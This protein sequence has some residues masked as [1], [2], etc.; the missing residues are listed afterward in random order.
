MD[1]PDFAAMCAQKQAHAT[2]ADARIE[3][4]QKQAATGRRHDTYGCPLGNH[5]HSRVAL[6]QAKKKRAGKRRARRFAL[7]G[8]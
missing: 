2:R 8:E 6:A 1:H 5:F 4:N 3:A 7:V